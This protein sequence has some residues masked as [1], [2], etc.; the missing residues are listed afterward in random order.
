MQIKV[1]GSEL[2]IRLPIDDLVFAFEAGDENQPFDEKVNDFRRSFKVSDKSQF[3]KGVA[4]GLRDEEEDGSTPLTRI[5]DQAFIYAVEGAYGVD[6]DGRIVTN[7]MLG[8]S[9]QVCPGEDHRDNEKRRRCECEGI[10]CETC[11]PRKGENMSDK[12]C[13]YTGRTDCPCMKSNKTLNPEHNHVEDMNWY[14]SC[15]ACEKAIQ[16]YRAR[17]AE[18]ERGEG[19]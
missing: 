8:F 11:R 4:L 16:V 1:E 5:L 2:V 18:S 6:K 19:G 3:A 7:E 17:R 9:T 12:L 14:Q 13:T 15:P 10:G